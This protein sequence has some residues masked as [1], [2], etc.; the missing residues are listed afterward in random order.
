MDRI[1]SQRSEETLDLAKRILAVLDAPGPV[2][3]HSSGSSYPE[4]RDPLCGY[5]AGRQVPGSP[6][7]VISDRTPQ[8]RLS[9][10]RCPDCRAIER[11]MMRFMSRTTATEDDMAI[12]EAGLAAS[13]RAAW[14]R[15][16]DHYRTWA[17]ARIA[18]E[19]RRS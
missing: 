10:T 2:G 1:S 6:G 3:P 12:Y 15:E 9:G 5:K 4:N 7:F 13:E 14:R 18:W 11:D 8:A 17:E 19:A 16:E